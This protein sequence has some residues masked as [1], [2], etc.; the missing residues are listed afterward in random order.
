M[1]VL[2]TRSSDVHLCTLNRVGASDFT[3]TLSEMC[4]P[5]MAATIDSKSDVRPFVLSKQEINQ[6]PLEDFSDSRTG[7]VSKGGGWRNIFS[8]PT[9]PTDSLNIGIATFPPRSASQMS[10]EAL[11]RHKQ[12]EFYYILSGQ[13]VVRIDDAK[14]EVGAGHALFIPGDAEHGFWNPSEEEALVFLWGFACDGF[15]EVVYQFSKGKNL[16]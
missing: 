6:L 10:F 3:P 15:K 4:P 8:A 14:Y 12:A 7:F 9:T 5:A 16:I 11:H 13:A 2:Y 1:A